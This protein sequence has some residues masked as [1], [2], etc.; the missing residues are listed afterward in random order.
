MAVH[1][2]RLSG[3]AQCSIHIRERA[4]PPHHMDGMKKF[5]KRLEPGTMSYMISK[6]RDLTDEGHH[7]IAHL[8]FYAPLVDIAVWGADLPNSPVM[9]NPRF[10]GAPEPIDI[11]MVPAGWWSDGTADPVRVR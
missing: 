7:W 4:L 9:Q 3:Q 8:M 5:V 6:D 10:S 2:S 1:L 11:F